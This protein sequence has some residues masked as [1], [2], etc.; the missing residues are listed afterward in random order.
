MGHLYLSK[1]TIM[2]HP[3]PECGAPENQYCRRKGKN[4]TTNH[5]AR[6]NVAK[7]AHYAS[8]KPSEK[9]TDEPTI[10]RL[11]Q[12]ALNRVR[13]MDCS[14]GDKQSALQFLG[15][16]RP[17]RQPTTLQAKLMKDTI[18]Y[19]GNFDPIDAEDRWHCVDNKIVTLPARGDL[20]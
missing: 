5:Q 18:R 9:I 13:A 6:V 4:S 2:G 11:R 17:G 1:G 19:A 14:E 20:I 16:S 8:L 10:E 12:A 3:C 7:K 15:A